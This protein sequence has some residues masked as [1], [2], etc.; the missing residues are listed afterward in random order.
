M[1][2]KKWEISLKRINKM[3]M[4][5][6]TMLQI[7]RINRK[8]TWLKRK[9]IVKVTVLQMK[10]KKKTLMNIKREGSL[11]KVNLL[12]WLI[13]MLLIRL[14]ISYLECLSIQKRLIQGY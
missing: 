10:K 6:M 11:C 5:M 7:K 8:R 4:I 3:M 12:Y 13:M 9:E 2:K 14:C 1:I